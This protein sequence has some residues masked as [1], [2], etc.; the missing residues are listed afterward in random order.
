MFNRNALPHELLL[1]TRQ[2]TKLK[3]A[4]NN[5]V[6]ADLKFSK[7]QISKIIQSGGFLGKLLG[8]LLKTGLPLIKNVIKP[9]VK[10]ALISLALTAAASAADAGIH[11]KIL[12][13]GNTTLIISNEE[14]ND[15]MKIVQALGDSNILLKGVTKTI[16]NETKN[17]KEDF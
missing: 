3:N 10:S 16:E 1:T 5:N 12:G 11:K 7:T 14:M 17:K 13:S 6:S 15:I 2:K 9:L 4:F 8:P